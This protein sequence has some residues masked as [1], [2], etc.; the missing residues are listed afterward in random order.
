MVGLGVILWKLDVFV[1]VEGYDMFEATLS[2]SGRFIERKYNIR[3]FALLD[4]FDEVLVCRDRRRSSWK[5]EDERLLRG[6]LKVV[7]PTPRSSG[8]G[9]AAWCRTQEIHYH[10]PLGDVVSD[11]LTDVGGLVADDETCEKRRRSMPLRLTLMFG[12]CLTYAY[13]AR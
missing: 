3:E 12:A 8:H 10:L 6:R 7:D 9:R 2:V 13:C 5:A 4:E 11:V 1:H